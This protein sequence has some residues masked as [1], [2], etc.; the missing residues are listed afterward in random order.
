MEGFPKR[1]REHIK[2]SASWK[3][4]QNK[5]PS[6]WIIREMTERDYGIDA[7]IEIV[8]PTGEVSGEL[9]LIQI[10]A[11]DSID[12]CNG[13]AKLRNIKKQTINYWMNLPV[14]V[15]IFLCDIKASRLFFCSVKDQVRSQY[16]KFLDSGQKTLGFDFPEDSELGIGPGDALFKTLYFR[17]KNYKQFVSYLRG[18]L[19]HSTEY[20]SCIIGK[21]GWDNLNN[22][23]EDQKLLF[24]HIYRTCRFISA[25]LGLKW[26]IIGL[27]DYHERDIT[28]WDD[29][30]FAIDEKILGLF[31][32]ELRVVFINILE[33]AKLFIT[34][35]MKEYWERKDPLLYRNCEKINIGEIEM[36]FFRS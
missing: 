23:T 17:E 32:F 21:K 4:F 11:T 30:S 5:T 1:T 18:L 8:P 9:C 16:N 2:E 14:P 33:K 22:V 27:T 19:V 6:E 15:F 7:Y 31:L 36:L 20:S 12:W 34:K 13:K 35:E 26:G 10:K 25:F 24:V 29:E 28:T 3:I